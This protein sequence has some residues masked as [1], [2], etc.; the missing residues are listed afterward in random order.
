MRWRRAC[1]PGTCRAP[2]ST[3]FRSSRR[4]TTTSSSRRCVGMDNVILT[5][6]VGGST[7][8]AQDNIGRE[9][10]AKLLRYSDNGTHVVRGQLPRS[11]AARPSQQS[12]SAAHPS[13]RARHPVA[14]QRDLLA[15]KHQHR[16][17]VPADRH[18][19]SATSSSTSRP[20]QNT[21]A[22]S[23]THSPQ[24]PAPFAQESCTRT[25][26]RLSPC[27]ASDLCRARNEGH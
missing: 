14:H 18:T 4:A 27:L 13:E 25:Q 22:N 2:R 11:L 12:A 7:L 15:R 23:R 9:V 10:A 21:P 26:R 6:H 19:A 16:R 8:E 3:C 24:S 17:A 5:P 1:S 20:L